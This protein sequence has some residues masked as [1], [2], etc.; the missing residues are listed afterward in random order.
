M[1]HDS[2]IT[3]RILIAVSDADLRRVSVAGLRASGFCVSAPT[4]GDAAV[5]LVESFSPDV[6]IVDSVLMSPCGRPLHER[7]RECSE[8]YLLCITDA[9]DDRL[10]TAVL[11][12][13][14]DD[15][16]SSPVHPDELA[17]RCHALLRRPRQLHARPDGHVASV[18]V[19]GPLTIDLGRREVAVE[20]EEVQ[21]TRIEFSLLEQLC[22]R[23]TE[24]CTRDELLDSVWGPK[25][26]GDSHVVDVHLSNLRRK[27]DKAAPGT[28][29]IH[30]VRGVGF[31]LAN[32]V[33][34]VLEVAP[35]P[36]AFA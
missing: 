34:D 27:L 28:K 33:T 21:T 35:T 26:V 18:L 11:H 12:A 15:A 2:T 24:V 32:D 20:D 13:G 14:A 29:V 17:A 7:M 8:Q 6:V 23:P 30:T 19:L 4:D 9:G 5:M 3:H 1:D 36:F 25:W 31:R 10:R 16:I 22:R